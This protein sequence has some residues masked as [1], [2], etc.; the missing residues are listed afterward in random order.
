[1]RKKVINKKLYDVDWILSNGHCYKTTRNCMWEDVVR[2]RK[3]AKMLGETI[4]YYH[5]HTAKYV[6]FI[7]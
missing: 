2:Y 7:D 1:M 5:V 6:Y 3:V 4:K